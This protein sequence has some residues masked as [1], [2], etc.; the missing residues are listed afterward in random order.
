MAE[1]LERAT[2]KPRAS[3]SSH[4]TDTKRAVSRGASLRAILL[5]TSA[6]ASA[7]LSATVAHAADGDATW[8]AT[9]PDDGDTGNF[10]NANH[11]DNGIPTAT[12]T[13]NKS[14][15][16]D[17]HFTD[18]GGPNGITLV[19]G[20]AATSGAGD[21]RFDTNGF[22]VSFT[23]AGLSVGSGASLTFNNN[24]DSKLGFFGIST[25]GQ[26]TINVNT[27]NLAFNEQSKGGTS[28][29]N[30]GDV[31][32]NTEG[33]LVFAGTSDAEQA[34]INVGLGSLQFQGNSS[35]GSAMID[36]SDGAEVHFTSS[37]A[38]ATI[39]TKGNVIFENTG[40]AGSASI[41][42]DTGGTVL[43]VDQSTA[44]HASI[45]L[46]AGGA[47]DISLHQTGIAVNSLAGGG[48]VFLGSKTLTVGAN[49]MSSTFS[50]G[51]HDG[52]S[53]AGFTIDGD[54][55]GVQGS[56][57]KVGTGSLALTGFNNDYTGA[58]TVNGGALIVDG[59][60]SSSS[61][62]TVNAG[63]TLGGSG[64]VSST[65]IHDGGTLAPGHSELA[66]SILTVS[67]DLTFTPGATYLTQVLSGSA[68]GTAVLG[69]ATLGGATVAAN[70]APGA[71]VTK[72]QYNI[73]ATTGAL[74]TDTFNP[75]VKTN[76]SPIFKLSLSYDPTDVFLNVN[77][78]ALDA[79]SGLNTNQR[80]VGNALINVFNTTG[81]LPGA[82][83]MLTTPQSLT[84]VSG[85]TAVGTQQAT[86]D[87]MNQ[88]MGVLL[89]PTL[90]VRGGA[91]KD[92]LAAMP[93]KAAPLSV[94]AF[95]SRWGVWA[96][97]FG[98]S[99]S[100]SG[101]AVLGSNKTTS[102]VFGSAVGIDYR[103]SPD[104]VAGFALAG[105]GTH[106]NVANGGSGN[107]D[108]FQAGAYVKH[109]EGAVFLAA[110]LAYGWQDVTTNR[111][112]TVFGI[113]SLRANFKTNAI[114]GRLEGGY[115]VATAVS[116]ITPYAAA[117]FTSY[118]LPSYM[119]QVAFGAGTFALNYDGKDVTASRTELGARAEKSFA[120]TDSL[121]TL[122]GRLAW[123][124][125]FNT[126]RNVQATFQALP[127]SAFVVNGAAP[128]ADT[129][130]ASVAA[131]TLW[132]SGWSASVTADAQLSDTTHSYSGKGVVRYSW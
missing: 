90:G 6:L 11:W 56:L 18:S 34:K 38:N 123:A 107:S 60:I 114:S 112:V 9:Q 46:L 106:F 103:F 109:T 47:L 131:E 126:D 128:A 87:A 22:N 102:N 5:A 73:L 59:D 12:A 94:E 115:R 15:T 122:R 85:E 57:T 26:A 71:T 104:T 44:D 99:Q 24:G 8:S 98:G 92:A 16:R 66:G 23:G 74:L 132:H 105:G 33:T 19:G 2:M 37:A 17:I 124:H 3:H 45:T 130:L 21:Y 125:D 82:F 41:T 27:G 95:D 75:S 72:Q 29:L 84:Q 64:A 69:S 88:F 129:A 42:A 118:R 50:G 54:H 35:A 52:S 28:T 89:D 68:T 49:G 30:V 39:T 83:A 117:Q 93:R 121:V 65:T 61:G 55:F 120:Q 101:D 76:L 1:H 25:A 13:F 20:I 31:T 51:I 119:E 116:D 78:A 86:F 97:G 43:F 62:V 7:A 108:L 10:N 81:S 113:D 96:A 14:D 48:D 110:A 67:G 40:T 4:Q 111:N 91:P 53:A 58:T 100:T 77:A 80:N 70:F 79:S 127:G 32:N 63:G 36:V